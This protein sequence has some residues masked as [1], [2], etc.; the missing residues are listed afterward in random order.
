MNNITTHNQNGK[1]ENTP[2]LSIKRVEYF[3]MVLFFALAWGFLP[4]TYDHKKTKAQNRQAAAERSR[5]FRER[6]KDAGMIVPVEG[7]TRFFEFNQMPGELRMFSKNFLGL[8]FDNYKKPLPWLDPHDRAVRAAVLD[9]AKK[10]NWVSKQY[11]D[12]EQ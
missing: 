12:A 6:A 3:P 7:L 9:Y 8:V 1:E 2:L 5:Q 4:W 10:Q 11:K